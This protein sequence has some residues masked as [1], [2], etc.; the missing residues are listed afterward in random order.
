MTVDCMAEKIN[1]LNLHHA[2]VLLMLFSY[3]YLLYIYVISRHNKMIISFIIPTS[4]LTS[5]S[6]IIYLLHLYSIK[7]KNQHL[8]DLTMCLGAV[9]Y[10]EFIVSN[11]Y[12]TDIKNAVA[13]NLFIIATASLCSFAYTTI[14]LKYKE[15]K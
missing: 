3:L 8:H 2:V 11:L 7:I 12:N 13:L 4:L 15:H 1:K 6:Y 5:F 14:H 9:I 10:I